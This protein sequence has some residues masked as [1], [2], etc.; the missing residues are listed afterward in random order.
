MMGTFVTLKLKTSI[1]QKHLEESEKRDYNLGKDIYITNNQ[2]S[3]SNQ[4]I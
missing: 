2:Q 1:Y 3:T 4:F